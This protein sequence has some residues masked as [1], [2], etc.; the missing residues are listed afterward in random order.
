MK[1]TCILNSA[2][3]VMRMASYAGRETESD[4]DMDCSN[5]EDSDSDL[6]IMA[7]IK[8]KANNMGASRRHPLGDI[9]GKQKT[10]APTSTTPK[11]PRK[12]AARMTQAES[13]T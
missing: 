7:A 1:E 12:A 8:H 13:G 5:H 2:V 11:T 6:H 4:L 9:T 10:N 3:N